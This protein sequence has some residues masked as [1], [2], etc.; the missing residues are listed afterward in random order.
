M[1]LPASRRGVHPDMVDDDGFIKFPPGPE[2][3]RLLPEFNPEEDEGKVPTVSEFGDVEWKFPPEK[4]LYRHFIHVVNSGSFNGWFLI[5]AIS[6]SSTNIDTYD[7][8]ADFA[9]QK[10]IKIIGRSYS[11]REKYD[12]FALKYENNS[13]KFYYSEASTYSSTTLFFG[14]L[15]F[16]NNATI[17]DTVTQIF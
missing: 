9:N 7:A 17:T 11:E 16:A 13:F 1:A 5:E 14:T 2:P 8:L 10:L 12:L 15:A 4:H 6:Q 3:E